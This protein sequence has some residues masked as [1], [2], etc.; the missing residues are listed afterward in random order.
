MSGLRQRLSLSFLLVA[1]TAV[2]FTA[3]LILW[4]G[5]RL[6]SGYL[7][8]T[9]SLR[10]QRLIWTLERTYATFGDWPGMR[11]A[12]EGVGGYL[13][14]MAGTSFLVRDEAGRVVF[15]TGRYAE[16]FPPEPLENGDWPESASAPGRGMTGPGW[17]R[18][19]GQMSG[20]MGMMGPYGLRWGEQGPVPPE[21]EWRRPLRVAG[22]EATYPLEAGG[23]RIGTITFALPRTA[24]VLNTF[25]ERFRRL[26]GLTALAAA[27]LA[28][29]VGWGSGLWL[30]R[31]LTQPIIAL[32]DATRRFAAGELGARVALPAGETPE[33]PDEIAE[34]GRSFDL[35]AERLERLEQVR[36]QL[37]ADVA[38]ELRTPVAAARNLVEA[39]RDGVLP[40]DEENLSA[41]NRELERLGRIV[42]DLRD[43]SVA[44]SGKLQLAR[45]RL[46]LREILDAAG[47]G[48][49]SHFAEAGI[50]FG[51]D[52]PGEPVPVVGDAAAL[53]RVFSN[54]LAN[55]LKYTGR[56][57]RVEVVLGR[58][59]NRALVRVA[60][61]GV[62]IPA[63]EQPL[64]FERFF[65][66]EAARRAGAEGT[67]VGLA[68]VREIV[69]AHGGEVVLASR[70]GE[71]TAV[72]VRIPLTT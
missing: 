7:S 51:V 64:V 11:D 20:G 16:T 5:S 65:R 23:R 41:L 8:S 56:G 46:D 62:G 34:L 6:F 24:G 36:R 13:G 69:Q 54:L 59:G 63:E 12:F 61:T 58:E 10:H 32:R 48:W 37:T 49:R 55:A 66:G 21:E 27:L 38:H 60:D 26:V 47:E 72:T 68:I 1:I 30:A 31:R 3:G 44:E 18:R 53:E 15:A 70:P 4:A 17:G 39:F 67:G 57:G 25:E 33:V 9:Q 52:L 29:A 43:L 40:P 14:M 42:G 35:M 50:A 71:G 19:F 2:S 45:D 22:G 28:A